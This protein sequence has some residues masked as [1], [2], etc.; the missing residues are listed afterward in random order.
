MAFPPRTAACLVVLATAF[1]F[2]LPVAARS[3]TVGAKAKKPSP[4]PQTVRPQTTLRRGAPPEVG[5]GQREEGSHGDSDLNAVVRWEDRDGALHY[6]PGYE[7]PQSSRPKV[8][9]VYTSVGV[10]PLDRTE[11]EKPPPSPEHATSTAGFPV[12]TL[13]PGTVPPPADAR[14]R[15]PSGSPQGPT[16]GPS[17]PAPVGTS[18]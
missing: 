3:R 1:A 6:A 12:I 17:L 5:A 18:R 11:A 14:Q 7:V 2:P 15:V 13:P 4:A 8:R 9:R 10:V 16:S